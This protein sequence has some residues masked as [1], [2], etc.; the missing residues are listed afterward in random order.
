LLS[1]ALSEG[2]ANAL[3]ND[4]NGR[5][6][7]SLRAGMGGMVSMNYEKAKLQSAI[8]LEPVSVIENFKDAESELGQIAVDQLSHEA[9]ANLLDGATLMKHEYAESYIEKA[10]GTGYR[11]AHDRA[12]QTFPSP[13]E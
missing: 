12:N 3:R 4:P 8:N 6:A 1:R 13:L 2:A 9:Q 11:E 10:N 7:S 5:I